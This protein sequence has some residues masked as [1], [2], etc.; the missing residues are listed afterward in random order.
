MLVVPVGKP[1]RFSASINLMAPSISFDYGL[2]P[3]LSLG[4]KK[5]FVGNSSREQL[6]RKSKTHEKSP[7]I[8]NGI[9]ST[10]SHITRT[11]NLTNNPSCE[12]IA[13]NSS[14]I[15]PYINEIDSRQKNIIQG[16]K[17]KSVKKAGNDDNP[18]NYLIKKVNS[19]LREALKRQPSTQPTISK[20]HSPKDSIFKDNAPQPIFN[21]KSP[22]AQKNEPKKIPTKRELP[23]RATNSKKLIIMNSSS[24]EA[25]FSF[26]S[27]G[28]V[29]TKSEM[30]TSSTLIETP[31][32]VSN[33]Q[34]V[35]DAIEAMPSTANPVIPKKKPNRGKKYMDFINS[36]TNIPETVDLKS[37]VSVVPKVTA[38]SWV[39]IDVESKKALFGFKVNVRREVASLTKL[40][41]LFTALDICIERN[42]DPKT[43]TCKVSKYSSS[44]IGTSANLKHDD[45]L[46][47]KDLFFGRHR[48]TSPDAPFGKR[49]CSSYLRKFR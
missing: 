10:P 2:K 46:T 15:F 45:H 9:I 23:P 27:R 32:P 3:L 25:N 5:I 26:K 19:N 13:A 28:P 18:N 33:L 20:M 1:S 35:P 30:P 31:S 48:S 24:R 37:I 22:A 6:A 29:Q 44:M 47:L 8:S 21:L 14:T 17:C 40:M 12:N 4:V 34:S 39:A 38:K 49:C 42:I 43:M 16:M 11:E 36:Q 7:K 41:T